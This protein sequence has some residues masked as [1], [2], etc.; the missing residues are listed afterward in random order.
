MPPQQAFLGQLLV[1]SL[2]QMLQAKQQ[3]QKQEKVVPPTQVLSMEQMI[4]LL[5]Q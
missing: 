3:E 5:S 2:I 4:N 1:Q